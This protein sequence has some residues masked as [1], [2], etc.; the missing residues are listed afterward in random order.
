MITVKARVERLEQRGNPAADLDFTM[1]ERLTEVDLAYGI[2]LA[3]RHARDFDGGCLR[4]L[5][6]FTTEERGRLQDML[7]LIRGAGQ[8]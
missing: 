2:E 8:G 4:D 5:S 7:W 6:C 1:L 3:K